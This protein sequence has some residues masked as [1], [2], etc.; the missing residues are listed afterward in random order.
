MISLSFKLNYS[1]F[2]LYSCFT[3]EVV[4]LALSRNR[5]GKDY[6]PSK[7]VKHR[8]ME[9]NFFLIIFNVLVMMKDIWPGISNMESLFHLP[10]L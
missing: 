8:W 6:I 3:D 1:A 10:V 2:S 5:N 9:P 7:G 4:E